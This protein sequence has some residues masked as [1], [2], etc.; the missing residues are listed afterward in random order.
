[1][2]IAALLTVR[3][4]RLYIKKCLEHLIS[5]GI[6]ICL[7]DN[8]STD[9][10]PAIASGFLGRGLISIEKLPY[11]GFFALEG[12]L[13]NEERL[14]DEINADWFIHHDADEI[15]E[16]PKPYK[17]LLE[18]IEAADKQGYNA[19]N[20]DEFVFLP[21]NM[22]ESFEGKDYVKGMKYY[23]FFE[24]SPLR[25][26]KAW[27]KIGSNIDLTNS[28]GHRAYF[29]GQKIFP[30]NFI[31][32]HYIALSQEHLIKKY[33]AR[34]FSKREVNDLGWHKARAYFDPDKL[35]LPKKEQLKTI[36]D[37]GMWDKTDPWKSHA[38]LGS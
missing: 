21:T 4:E 3:N 9:G 11:K 34:V 23:Y 7:V 28:G 8:G 16:A 37:E 31:L 17:T 10:T 18:G 35:F 22:E 25:Q 6:E 14:A 33:S 27:K 5:Q 1:M 38:F 20:F 12:I 24:P 19:I 2:R 32:R 26:I 15:R 30:N 13:K 36:S 29:D